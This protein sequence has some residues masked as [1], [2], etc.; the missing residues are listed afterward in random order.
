MEVGELSALQVAEFV[1][2]EEGHF[3][4]FKARMVSPGK[5]TK[6]LSAFANADGGELVIGVSELGP[7]AFEWDGFERIEDANGHL[8]HLEEYF[9]HGT[10]FAYDFLLGE[11]HD[12]YVLR[13]TALKSRELRPASDGI[14]YLRRGAQSLP[15]TDPERILQLRRAK[16]LASFEDETLQ[17][18]LEEVTNSIAVLEFAFAIV[19]DTEPERWLRKQ[20]LIVDDHPTVAGGLLFADEPQ[21]VLPKADV[22]I[23][24][25]KTADEEGSRETLV[26]DPVTVEGSLYRQVD[27]AVSETVRLTEQ[28]QK[29]TDDGLVPIEYPREALHEV[30]TNALLHRDYAHTDDVHVRIFDNRIEVESPGRLPAHITPGNI[31]DERFAR[32]PTLVRIINK[33]PDPPNKDVGEGL[34]TAFAAMAKLR[35]RAPEIIERE[36]SVLVV[37]RHESLASPEQLIVEYLASN[38]SINNAEARRVTGIQIDHQIRRAFKRLVA[39]GEIEQVPGTARA[40]TRYRL[41]VA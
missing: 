26:F 19:P 20:R 8:Q 10:D 4:D 34:N 17:L 5:M 3:L 38:E 33:F 35:L 11:E 27:R 22:K 23:Y 24:R 14:L 13:V 37:I 41:P 30:I 32:N 39:A 7:N 36:N 1:G 6:A 2:R 28:I 18:D 31:L 9:P 16:G 12:G 21:V 25:Y 29:M 40:T 15:V